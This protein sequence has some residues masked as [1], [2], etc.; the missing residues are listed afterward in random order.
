[1]QKDAALRA[2]KKIHEALTLAPSPVQS[3]KTRSLRQ[4]TQV[5]LVFSTSFFTDLLK[6]GSN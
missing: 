1:L 5:T 2:G 4:V 3:V 6:S